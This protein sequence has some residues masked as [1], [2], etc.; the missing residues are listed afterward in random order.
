MAS[1]KTIQFVALC[2][3][4]LVIIRYTTRPFPTTMSRDR[5]VP[6]TRNHNGYGEDSMCGKTV[7]LR[8]EHIWG[9]T[10]TGISNYTLSLRISFDALASSLTRTGEQDKSYCS[11]CPAVRGLDLDRSPAT[12]TF[13]RTGM[14]PTVAG[15]VISRIDV[16]CS[17]LSHPQLK[18]GSFFTLDTSFYE[19]TPTNFH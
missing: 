11:M 5:N 14:H 3:R 13:P 18:L 6:I 8:W 12:R 15:C 4:S 19:E 16:T 17:Q 9:K 10:S 7:P 1:D 2:S